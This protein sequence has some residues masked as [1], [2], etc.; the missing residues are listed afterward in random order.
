MKMSKHEE[1]EQVHPWL[2]TRK[3]QQSF[4][5]RDDAPVSS[6]DF[7]DPDTLHVCSIGQMRNHG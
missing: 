5:S 4:L 1:R 7:S 6:A 2:F 3:K